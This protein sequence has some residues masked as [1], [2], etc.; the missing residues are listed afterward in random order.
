M[1]SIGGMFFYSEKYSIKLFLNFTKD[2]LEFRFSTVLKCT[3]KYKY[4]Y[5]NQW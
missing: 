2:Y 3:Y 4:I 5:L 1:D